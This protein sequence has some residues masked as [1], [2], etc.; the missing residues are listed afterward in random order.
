[1]PTLQEIA[2]MKSREERVAAYSSRERAGLPVTGDDDNVAAETR[3]AN[4]RKGKRP[5]LGRLIQRILSAVKCA[6]E[7]SE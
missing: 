4:S 2:D 6:V 7:L 1:M 3:E 5:S